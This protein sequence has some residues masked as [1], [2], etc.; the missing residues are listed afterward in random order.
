MDVMFSPD[1]S[2]SSVSLGTIG[3]QR[4][5]GG[6]VCP[7]KNTRSTHIGGN[8]INSRNTDRI[9]ESVLK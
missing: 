2:D 3:C 5:R 9:S 8:L 6:G 4:G 1:A 7:G